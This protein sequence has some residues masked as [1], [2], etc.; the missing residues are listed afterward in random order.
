MGENMYAQVEKP[1]E[2]IKNSKTLNCFNLKKVSVRQRFSFEYSKPESVAQ[3]K[4]IELANN[5]YQALQMRIAKDAGSI[6]EKNIYSK[7]VRTHSNTVLQREILVGDKWEKHT[8][9]RL[10]DDIKLEVKPRIKTWLQFD[11][12]IYNE[13]SSGDKTA[14]INTY[15]DDILTDVGVTK[16][17]ADILAALR[18]HNNRNSFDNRNDLCRQVTQDVKLILVGFNNVAGTKHQDGQFKS[19]MDSSGVAA[20]G[21]NKKLVIY[22]T[23][24]KAD[25]LSYNQSRD[26]DFILKGHGGSLGQAMHYLYKSRKNGLD[27]ILVEVKFSESASNLVD[28]TRIAAGGEGKGPHNRKLTGKKEKNDIMGFGGEDTDIFSINLGKSKDFIKGL[29]PVVRLVETA[30]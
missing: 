25:W 5:S 12:K 23:M 21:R 10:V 15:F 20:S 8:D 27:N 11:K 9:Q 26:L 4:A 2:N 7:G 19:T 13:Y 22:R 3:C 17:E 24:S 18:K 30:L 14:A 29:N 28:Y 1:K 16:F 6:G